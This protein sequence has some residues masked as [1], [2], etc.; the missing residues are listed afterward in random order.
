MLLFN[1]NIV[2]NNTIV[3]VN[4]EQRS[5]NVP[6]TSFIAD[7][8]RWTVFDVSAVCKGDERMRNRQGSCA[9]EANCFAT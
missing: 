1:K 9:M 4:N 6:A 7:I 8:T 5:T 2:F 3:F